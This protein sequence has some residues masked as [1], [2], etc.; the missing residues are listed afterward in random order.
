[1][2]RTPHSAIPRP[3]LLADSSSAAILARFL[4]TWSRQSNQG[5]FWSSLYLGLVLTV[6]SVSFL[7][8]I[9]FFIWTLNASS[10]IHN[11]MLSSVLKSPISF[12]HANP[13]GR[14]L[15][16]FSADQGMMDDML[17]NTFFNFLQ[18]SHL[19]RARHSAAHFLLQISTAK[20]Q[21][22]LCGSLCLKIMPILCVKSSPSGL[23]LFL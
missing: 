4:A 7:R 18:V 23:L 13:V 10:R 9:L 22:T 6:V 5:G 12:F 2:S 15:N 3:S 1:M 8:S 19:R 11:R 21:I 17:P 16:R 14:V 20:Q